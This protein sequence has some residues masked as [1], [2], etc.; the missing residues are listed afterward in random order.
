MNDGD[1]P[2]PFCPKAAHQGVVGVHSSEDGG[3]DS[4]KG[5]DVS[6]GR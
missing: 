3:A 6:C 1:I 2:E 4:N 5:G